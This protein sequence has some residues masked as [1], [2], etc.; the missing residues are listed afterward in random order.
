MFGSLLG[1]I[2]FGGVIYYVPSSKYRW[3]YFGVRIIWMFPILKLCYE[4]NYIPRFLHVNTH[5]HKQD[6]INRIVCALLNSISTKWHIPTTTSTHKMCFSIIMTSNHTIILYTLAARTR[7]RK[8]F[9]S[10][11]NSFDLWLKIG[12][13]ELSQDKMPSTH[14]QEMCGADEIWRN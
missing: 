7:K 2:W 9:T 6:E 1:M 13:T 4:T 11:R 8:Y 5:T 10:T 3:V 14:I 12:W